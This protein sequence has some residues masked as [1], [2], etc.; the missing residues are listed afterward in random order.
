[1]VTNRQGFRIRIA[2]FLAAVAVS[3][4]A[5]LGF[6]P[7]TKAGVLCL[8]ASVRSILVVHRDCCGRVLRVEK[9][10]P[11]L[12]EREFVQCRCS[13]KE[14]AGHTAIASSK[15]VLFIGSA[16]ATVEIPVPLV[17]TLGWTQYAARPGTLSF[18][19]DVP[20]PSA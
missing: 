3:C 18:P 17:L 13:E 11:R 16:L 6:V 4:A 19:P 7:V 1:M 9:R 14:S 12:G 20:P 2:A 10:T 5:I 15:E 8:T